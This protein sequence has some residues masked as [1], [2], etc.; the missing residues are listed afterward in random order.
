MPINKNYKQAL[1]TG[2]SSGLGLEFS[3]TLLKQGLTVYATSRNINNLP[4]HPN[5]IPL[6]I[7]LLQESE[8]NTL[9]QKILTGEIPIDILINNAGAGVFYDFTNLPQHLISDQIQLLLKTPILL[10]QAAFSRMKA[11]NYGMII[12]VSSLAAQYPLPNMALYNTTKSALSGFTTSLM[13]ENINSN[14]KLVDLQPG[15]FRT[16][17][18]HSIILDPNLENNPQLKKKWKAVD[19]MFNLSPLPTKASKVLLKI[20]RKNKSGRYYSGSFFQ[21]TLGPFFASLFPIQ[22]KLFLFK[23]Y[24][25]LFSKP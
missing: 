10:T 18:N 6:Q 3:Q 21:A 24:I 20:I 8:V 11:K 1:I 9:C 16:N 17:F 15:D 23:L 14:I 7:D 12:N 5:L 19:R 13:I 2:A 4:S 25:S 22:L